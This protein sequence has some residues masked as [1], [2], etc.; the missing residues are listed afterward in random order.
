MTFSGGLKRRAF[1]LPAWR[2]ATTTSP[3]EQRSIL[4]VCTPAQHH[5]VIVVLMLTVG[6]GEGDQFLDH[7]EL[8]PSVGPVLKPVITQRCVTCM[9]IC[10]CVCCEQSLSS[11]FYFVGNTAP[12]VHTLTIQSQPTH[13]DPES[14]DQ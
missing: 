13:T 1:T 5:V 8:R 11:L 12:P 10:I 4:L 7:H 6:E 2:H 9:C 14:V 3:R